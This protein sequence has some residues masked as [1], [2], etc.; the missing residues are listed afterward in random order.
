MKKQFSLLLVFGLILISMLMILPTA[1][2]SPRD[3]DFTTCLNSKTD[4]EDCSFVLNRCN[5]QLDEKYESFNNEYSTCT[6]KCPDIE[7]NCIKDECSPDGC[8]PPDG[9][10]E[11]GGYDTG[12]HCSSGV[13]ERPTCS[14]GRSCGCSYAKCNADCEDSAKPCYDDCRKVIDEQ[15]AWW[16]YN[17]QTSDGYA[18]G[19]SEIRS[20]SDNFMS[21]C[22]VEVQ[23]QEEVAPQ[24][25]ISAYTQEEGNLKEW[26]DKLIAETGPDSEVSK[27]LDECEKT[28]QDT[29]TKC[30]QSSGGWSVDVS[31]G[32][33]DSKSGKNYGFQDYRT[34][35]C[36]KSQKFR[37]PLNVKIDNKFSSAAE[38]G[39]QVSCNMLCS[40]WDCEDTYLALV[41]S[42]KGQVGIIRNG[43]AEP[44]GKNTP[45]QEGD[46]IATGE[47]G[48]ISI[49]LVGGEDKSY[50]EV[51][52]NSIVLISD[53]EVGAVLVQGDAKTHIE[54]GSNRK[55]TITTPT[56]RVVAK[57]T[58]FLVS[59]E[60]DTGKTDVEL[61]EGTLEVVQLA[62]NEYI[63]INSNEKV[64]V[65]AQGLGV[66][67]K[68]SDEELVS[69]ADIITDDNIT[70]ASSDKAKGSSFVILI[71][72]L[73]ILAG[74]SGGAYYFFKKRK[75]Q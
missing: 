1:T 15:N 56:S 57:G 13:S 67:A 69:D 38:S 58:D 19:N 4:S 42:Y 70:P 63:T 65:D 74:I 55:Y 22:E 27:R 33:S 29:I 52:P 62:T 34:G 26:E 39:H 73:L 17:T 72:A 44:L 31:M 66:P 3:N 20:L 40:S 61:Y 16:G 10:G 75:V 2:A 8:Y 35:G 21:S 30:Q 41:D 37:E 5:G 24:E 14:D 54:K 60:A 50:V 23:A 7:N 9:C 36:K 45:I 53:P 6:L 68:I 51:K 18:A 32:I 12:R 25:E 28:K 46:I 71:M 59:V 11:P 64:T 47:D 48:E 43:V 49:K